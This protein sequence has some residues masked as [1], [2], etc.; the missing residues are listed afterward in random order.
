MNKTA[1]N[2]TCKPR[3]V[4]VGGGYVGWEVARDMD[5]YADITLIE[6]REAFVHVSAMIR[7]LV[8]PSLLDQAIIPYDNLLSAGRVLRA[9]VA[10]VDGGGVVLEN[11]QRIPADYIVVATGSSYAAPF[12]PQGTSVEPLRASIRATHERLRVVK[13]IA[14]VGAGAVGTELA[15]EIVDAFPDKK[16]TLIT[17]ESQLFP[18]YPAKLGVQLHRKLNARGVNIIFNQRVGNLANTS[19]PYTGQLVLAD[20]RTI[21]ADLIFPVIGATGDATLLKSLPGS[22]VGTLGRV[23]T[24]PWMRPS[25]YTNVFAAGDAAEMGDGMTIVATTRQIPWLVKALKMLIAGK[26][27]ERIKPYRP[28]KLPPILLPLGPAIGSS[29]LP[30][31]VVGDFVTSR[32]KG[33]KLFIPKYRKAFR[34]RAD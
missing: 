6:Q 4:V 22:R 27:I 34:A 26:A 9:R 14:I 20:G 10:S 11:G 24:D 30:F 15:G 17:S 3:I 28:W 16:I 1:M 12:K 29:Y 7:S 33:R 25:L 31:G 18:M 5:A 2:T 13:N 32:F 19:K 8:Q 23:I 21:E